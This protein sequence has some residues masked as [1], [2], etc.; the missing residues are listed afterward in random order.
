[1]LHVPTAEVKVFVT[2]DDPAAA[3]PEDLALNFA[4]FFGATL[5]IDAEESLAL[6]GQDKDRYLHQFKLGLEQAFAHG[7]FLD[8]PTITGLLAL[9][10]YLVRPPF[11]LVSNAS[12]A[13]ESKKN[14]SQ[15]F[16]LATKAKE[17]GS[18]TA[19]RSASR[20]A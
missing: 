18:Y 3:L 16:V 4:I 15:C 9:A 14:H 17:Y 5:S 6:F 1:M 20:T 10:I 2:I 11:S 13:P 12:S 8:R 19:S 7:G